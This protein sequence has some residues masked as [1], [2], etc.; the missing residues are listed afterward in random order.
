M[1]NIKTMNKISEKGLKLFN[2]QY[3][4]DV[5]VENEDG[6]LVRSAKLHDY[7]FPPQCLAVAR[8]GAGV[9]NIP[10]DACS[11]KGI[12]VFNTPGANANAVK[13]LV[14]C[15]LFLSARHVLEGIEWAKTIEDDDF[16]K[17]V[18][19]GKGKF[20]GPELEGKKLGVVGLGAIGVAVANAAVKLGMEVYGYDP[21]MSITAAW[22]LS[23]WVHR[24][25]NNE[26]I[27]KECD[28]I[29]LHVPANDETRE[30]INRR[31]MHM[32]KEG[33]HII[34]FARD[35]LINEDD[36]VYELKRGRVARYVTDFGSVR[37]AHT[38]NVVVMPHLGASTPESEENCATMAVQEIRDYLENG[39]ITN[40]VNMP[41]VVEPR[42]TNY[43][44][45]VIHR[46]Q[47]NMLARFAA[48]FAKENMNIE[49]MT[50][51]S[52]GAYGYTILD[53]NDLSE[54]ITK[55]IESLEGVVRARVI[56]KAVF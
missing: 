15:A 30:M 55:T 26:E 42:M 22:G 8:A 18:E 9:N 33:V 6:I 11:E 48:A 28:Y 12:V 34:N 3:H 21:Y 54:G 50:N 53:S 17:V 5:D 44:V 23:K 51:R 24:A 35:A 16:S 52:R 32:M 45:C 20:V 41:T 19:K 31:A 1:Y 4:V 2:K 37:L 46:N 39:N 13:E 25:A 40:S 29:T 14:L 36:M 38:E 43:R 47:P 49:T 56:A 27:F 10:I 7:D